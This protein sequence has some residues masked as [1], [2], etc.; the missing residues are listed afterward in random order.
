MIR[1]INPLEAIPGSHEVIPG[2]DRID[3]LSIIILIEGILDM[4]GREVNRKPLQD[5]PE[6]TDVSV[7]LHYL[8]FLTF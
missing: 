7:R 5:I 8:P 1:L 6:I 4:L 3:K 2:I